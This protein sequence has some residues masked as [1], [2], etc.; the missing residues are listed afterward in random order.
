M[1]T[2]GSFSIWHLLVLLIGLAFF[3]GGIALVVWL[4]VRVAR[5]PNTAAVP[6]STQQRLQQL[7][8]LR[9]KGLLS[10]AEY[11]QQR[12]AIVSSI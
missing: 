1:E 8:E 3:A 5:K 6:A 9:E 11:Q 12:G 2:M 10:G 4:C 7:E